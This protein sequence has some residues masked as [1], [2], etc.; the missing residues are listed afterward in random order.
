MVVLWKE[1]VK[2]NDE[3]L[4]KFIDNRVIKKFLLTLKSE[5]WK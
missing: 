3:Y 2:N 1:K 4:D 5:K